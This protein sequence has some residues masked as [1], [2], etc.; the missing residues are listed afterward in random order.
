MI[1]PEKIPIR[2]P[3]NSE[4]IGGTP[5]KVCDDDETPYVSAICKNIKIEII[6]MYK[7]EIETFPIFAPPFSAFIRQNFFRK[8]SKVLEIQAGIIKIEY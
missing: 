6:F 1:N 5:T 4:L 7:Y 2:S 8:V 3:R